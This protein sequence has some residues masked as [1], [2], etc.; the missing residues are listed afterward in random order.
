MNEWE[1]EV[2]HTPSGQYF[3]MTGFYEDDCDENIVFEDISNNLS[4]N[5]RK[6]D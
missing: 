6:V 3:K 5:V 4:I 1:I 2:I